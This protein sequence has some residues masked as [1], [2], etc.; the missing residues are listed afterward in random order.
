[1][2]TW[3]TSRDPDYAAKKVR[4]EHL[5][6]IADGDDIPEDGEPE[7]IVRLDEF[8]PLDLQPHPGRQRAE[9]GGRHKNPDR[10]RGP[11]RRATYTRSL[12]VRH[13]FAAYVLAE[14]QL[15][16]HITMTKNR[17]KFLE[18]CRYLRSLV[19]RANVAR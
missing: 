10:E 5:Y 13:L 7:V 2:K 11:R 18:F 8:G 3:K 15:Y 1:M 17:S 4:V 6:A 14:E 19:T 16:G 12:G 9:R